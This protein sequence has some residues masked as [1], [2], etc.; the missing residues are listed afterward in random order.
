M[1]FIFS[2]LG[3]GK[4]VY[5]ENANV[6]VKVY[7]CIFV[8]G[9]ATFQWYGSA[10][11]YHVHF[12]SFP[13]HIRHSDIQQPN[14]EHVCLAYEPLFY[15]TKLKLTSCK[16]KL[17][18]MHISC[19]VRLIF[20]WGIRIAYIFKSKCSFL[21]ECD[22]WLS[23]LRMQHTSSQISVYTFSLIYLKLWYLLHCLPFEWLAVCMLN[24]ISLNI[25]KCFFDTTKMFATEFS[26]SS[27]LNCVISLPTLWAKEKLCLNYNQIVLL[28]FKLF[29]EYLDSEK[30]QYQQNARR[31]GRSPNNYIV[32]CIEGC[33]RR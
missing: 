7:W 16:I 20:I 28:I 22:T 8:C 14:L 33:I 5:P 12:S 15:L 23:N 29:E 32:G 26:S 1:S 10:S 19:A 6:D 31:N 21:S 24:A 4:K 2:V 17:N 18:T 11:I 25:I 30:T 9:I 13:Q 3:L 27:R